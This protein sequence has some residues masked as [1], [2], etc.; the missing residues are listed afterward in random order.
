MDPNPDQNKHLTKTVK[1]KLTNKK[2]LAESNSTIHKV[3]Q[4]L[5][6]YLNV[7][8]LYPETEL[9]NHMVNFRQ[10]LYKKFLKTK[11][12]PRTLQSLLMTSFGFEFELIKP[13]AEQGV[14][15]SQEFLLDVNCE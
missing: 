7:N 9:R 14:K 1:R 5:P 12:E 4:G 2:S 10:L 3:A 6:F 13:I 11:P 8:T 15:V